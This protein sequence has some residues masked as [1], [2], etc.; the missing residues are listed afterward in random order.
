MPVNGDAQPRP[1]ALLIS[2]R[3]REPRA[4][5]CKVHRAVERIEGPARSICGP[6]L[7][8]LLEQDCG[9]W[10]EGLQAFQN[11]LLRGKIG[12]RHYVQVLLTGY[13]DVPALHLND[14]R[15]CARRDHVRPLEQGP[16]VGQP[17]P[18]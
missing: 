8:G 9:S 13:I 14:F 2:N 17:S 3:D 15:R 10:R 7:A 16:K 11:E 6:P 5:A 18:G 12:R 4:A 1:P